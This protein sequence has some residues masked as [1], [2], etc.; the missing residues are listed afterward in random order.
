MFISH[1]PIFVYICAIF[2]RIISIG[3]SVLA[4]GTNVPSSMLISVGVSVECPRS[5]KNAP[6]N[7]AV[8]FTCQ[9]LFELSLWMSSSIASLVVRSL[10]GTNHC[11]TSI[12][13]GIRLL[14]CF[15]S[16]WMVDHT[17]F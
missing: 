3:P 17:F 8:L 9:N 16:L 15:S 13:V 6:W 12:L 7:I 10:G 2:S 11:G 5:L 1:Y 14:V 4:R